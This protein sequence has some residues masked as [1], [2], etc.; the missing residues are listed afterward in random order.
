MERRIQV[1]EPEIL[2][3]LVKF[4]DYL[5][6]GNIFKDGIRTMGM[7]IVQALIWFIDTISGD[8]GQ[9][10]SIFNFRNNDAVKDVMTKLQPI[11]NLLLGLAILVIGIIL[12]TGKN[13]EMRNVPLNVFL[14]ICTLSMLPSLLTSSVRLLEAVGSEFS[15]DA[16]GLGFQTLKNNTYDVYEL[17]AKG[18]TTDQLEEKNY[19]DDLKFFDINERITDAK[20]V[21]PDGVLNY[22]ATNKING[23]G[24]DIKKIDASE[25]VLDFFVKKLVTPS[26]YR[27]RVYWIPVLITLIA[28]AGATGL[29]V[30]RAGRLGL[31]TTFNYIWANITAFAHIRDLKKFKQA[32]F[33]I[34]VGL[35]TLG[36]LVALFYLYIS[37]NTYISNG[38]ESMIVK[39]LLYVGGAWLLFDGPAIIQKQLGVDAGLSTAGGILAGLG[40][41]KAVSGIGNAVKTG[42]NTTAGGAGMLSGLLDGLKDN[43][44]SGSKDPASKS[45]E[46]L[47]GNK[48]KESS[49]DKGDDSDKDKEGLDNKLTPSDENDNDS[50][51]QNK[52]QNEDASGGNDPDNTPS[53]DESSSEGG[54]NDKIAESDGDDSKN[55]DSNSL[56]SIEDG[57]NSTSDTPESPLAGMPE[58]DER[59]DNDS[60]QGNKE[61]NEPKKPVRPKN[62]I[63]SFVKT[64]L[65]TPKS[66]KN[67]KSTVGNMYESGSKGRAL[68]KD[69]VQYTK[70]RKEYKEAKRTHDSY[71]KK[72]GDKK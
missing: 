4:S 29:F 37:F 11:Q 13:G 42:A 64:E 34:F 62:P 72:K 66:M 5:E 6:I 68:G 25:S 55:D 18:W 48:D 7:L 61:E 53:D 41:G 45:K 33:E 57:L 60:S 27:W 39:A 47:F 8:F 46:G 30:I 40:A 9:I 63:G 20:K 22:E 54:I 10:F 32:V 38:S 21:D 3:I 70:D 49:D 44:G 71:K 56:N 24:Y 65:S 1:T 67:N 59:P 35:I 23:K 51:D 12:Y 69:L 31:E 14:I 17:G 52:N 58:Q 43:D 16:G 36:S 50:K 15:S 2:K 26:Y 28:L 19:L